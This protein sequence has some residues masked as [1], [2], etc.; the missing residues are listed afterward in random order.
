MFCQMRKAGT[1]SQMQ[2]GLKLGEDRPQSI[3]IDAGGKL[4]GFPESTGRPRF[5][6]AMRMR[7]YITNLTG[8][9]PLDSIDS[10]YIPLE[11]LL[12]MCDD[13]DNSYGEDLKDWPK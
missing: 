8:Q 7:H 5:S 6:A 10:N 11:K 13:A 2:E 1:L 3:V 12:S 9:Q 4:H